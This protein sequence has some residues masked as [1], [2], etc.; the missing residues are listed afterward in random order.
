VKNVRLYIRIEFG[1]KNAKIGAGKA[2]HA[3]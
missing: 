1:L 3:I 2:I